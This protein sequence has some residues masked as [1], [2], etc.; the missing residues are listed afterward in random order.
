MNFI[1]QSALGKHKEF[2]L[3]MKAAN[4][5]QAYIETM[6]A[7]TRALS[8]GGPFLGPILAAAIKVAGFANIAAIASS[9]FSGGMGKGGGTGS[10]TSG[11]GVGGQGSTLIT[12]QSHPAPQNVQIIVNGN[13]VDQAAFVR[14]LHPYFKEV[15]IDTL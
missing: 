3:I 9:S 15:Q 8:E 7:A 1:T 4:M 10:S 12:N 5:S 13:I 6:V 11:M 2:F 14:E